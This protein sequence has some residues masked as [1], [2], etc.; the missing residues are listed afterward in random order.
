WETHFP[1]LKEI[2]P[3]QLDGVSAYDFYLY[4]NDVRRSLIR[5]EAD[6]L[7]YPLH[8][9]IRYEIEKDVMAGKIEAKDIPTVWN[10]KYKD[11]L[12][13]DVPCDRDGCLQDMHWSDGSLGYFPTYALGSAYAAQ[14]YDAM[15]KDIDIDGAL[16]EGSVR[17]LADWLKEHLHKYGSSKYPKELIK[18]ATGKDFDPHYY[19]DYL[20]SK[21]GELYG[22]K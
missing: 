13:V 11:Y 10:R 16:K 7:T 8:V 12:G 4:V 14:I 18:L 2:F 5:T 15:A 20:K 22:I 21:Y 19:V 6:E 9:L 1:K 3:E 17:K